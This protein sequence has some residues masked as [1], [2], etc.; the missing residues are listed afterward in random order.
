[1]HTNG[2]Q[3]YYLDHTFRCRYVSG[4]AHVADEESVEVAWFPVSDLPDMDHVHQDRIAFAVDGKE[5]TR[6]ER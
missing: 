1:V 3:V 4:T 5:P 6:F 2:D